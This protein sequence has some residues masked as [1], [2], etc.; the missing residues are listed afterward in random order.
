MTWL[1]W[2]QLRLPVAVVYALVAAACVWLAL[3]GPELA[4][5]AR[6]SDDLFGALTS[7]DRLLYNGGI[8]VLAL[9]PALLGVFYGDSLAAALHDVTRQ[10]KIVG[11]LQLEVCVLLADSGVRVDDRRQEKIKVVALI[12]RQ[13]GP[14]RLAFAVQL[15]ATGARRC[16]KLFAPR[17]VTAIAGNEFSNHGNAFL[18]LPRSLTCAS[19][20]FC[21]AFI[22]F[23]VV[24]AHPLEWHQPRLPGYG[25]IDWARFM[26]VL[27]ETG[28]DGPVCIE[29]EDDTFG[30]TLEGRKRALRVARNVL[31]P[32]FA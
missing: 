31:A 30:K 29:V 27:M 15:V 16:K 21:C 17:R 8:A 12:A 32:Y 20:K 25:E 18:Q 1:T 9:V 23:F 26:A 3:T 5:L 4:R 11:G 22:E 28:Y 19:P 7:T 10:Q 2:R 24:F 14:D 6:T 13:V